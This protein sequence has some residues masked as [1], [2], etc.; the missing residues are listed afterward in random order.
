MS[1]ILVG[2]CSEENLFHLWDADAAREPEFE[3][4]VAKALMCVYPNYKCIIFGGG[5]RFYDQ[6]SKPDLAL[7]AQ[8]YSHWF[9]IE[10]ELTS[11]SLTRHVLPQ[12]RAFQYGTPEPDCVNVLV[13]E[14]GLPAAQ[15]QTFLNV[16]PRS[17]A[18]I[19]N[20]KNREWE[21]ALESHQVQYLSVSAYKSKAGLQAIEIDGRLS[22]LK[23][24]LGYGVFSATD[25]SLRFPRAVSLPD[26]EIMID[27]P[28][29]VGAIWTVSRD[30]QYAWITRNLGVPDLMHEV[31]VQLVRE[32]GGRISIRT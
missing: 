6:V 24:H 3:Y 2:E 17:V 10:V 29:G 18:V 27:G 5:F 25:R 30:T 20:R 13:R 28:D 22:V 31:S 15:V 14:T 11:H 12:V 23:E 1:T 7:I 26:G 4:I 21:I 19:A 32:H 8:D 9:I 16:V